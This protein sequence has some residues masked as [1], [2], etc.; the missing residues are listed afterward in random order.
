MWKTAQQ[1]DQVL[2][3][4]LMQPYHTNRCHHAPILQR[5][6]CSHS[7]RRN[8]LLGLL[9]AGLAGST[10]I[11][12]MKTTVWTETVSQ[13]SATCVHILSCLGR[14]KRSRIIHDLT[15]F[16]ATNVPSRHYLI[17][18]KQIKTLTN[19]LMA[20]WHVI[21]TSVSPI[22]QLQTIALQCQIWRLITIQ[23]VNLNYFSIVC[24]VEYQRDSVHDHTHTLIFGGSIVTVKSKNFSYCQKQ[25]LSKAKI[26]QRQKFLL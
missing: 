22:I 6:C 1:D 26:L 21:I 18:K 17:H 25:I 12:C 4:Y 19:T 8:G 15:S 13:H 7:A 9:P 14:Q 2:N 11:T 23:I 16:L 3:N 5:C 20:F 10:Q 24:L